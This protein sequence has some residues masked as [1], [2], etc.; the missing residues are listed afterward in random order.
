MQNLR[1]LKKY[2]IHWRNVELLRQF[3]TINGNIKSR[4]KNYLSDADQRATRK[5]IKTARIMGAMP[6]LGRTPEPLK[7]NITT[8]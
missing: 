5:A 8:L 6:Y 1:Q 4:Y 3:T 7:R 2:D